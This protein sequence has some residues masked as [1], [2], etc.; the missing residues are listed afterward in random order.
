MSVKVTYHLLKV[1]KQEMRIELD[2]LKAD[3]KGWGRY[4]CTYVVL[5]GRFTRTSTDDAS[6]L[7]FYLLLQPADTRSFG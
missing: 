5:G 6:A 2:R 1:K 4:I 3:V 7:D